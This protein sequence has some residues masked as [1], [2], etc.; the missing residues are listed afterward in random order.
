MALEFESLVPAGKWGDDCR[1]P[2]ID[3]S[4]LKRDAVMRSIPRF[5]YRYEDNTSQMLVLE[6]NYAVTEAESECDPSLASAEILDCEVLIPNQKLISIGFG[7]TPYTQFMQRFCRARDFVRF[8]TIFMGDGSIDMGQPIAG[9]FLRYVLGELSGVLMFRLR[10]IF[11]NGDSANTHEFDGVLTQLAAGPISTGGGCELYNHVALDWATLTGGSGPTSVYA[12]IDVAQDSILIHGKAYTGNAGKSLVFLLRDWMVAV[13]E[14]WLEAWNELPM[15]FD[16]WVPKGMKPVLAE[17]IACM[18]PCNGC[19]NPMEDPLIRD[20]AASFVTTGKV[21]FYPYSDWAVTIRETRYLNADS[22]IILM[23]KM[24]GNRPT[25]GWVFRDQQR[26]QDILNGLLPFYGREIGGIN[27]GPPLYDMT[28]ISPISPDMFEE[29]AFSIDVQK[30]GNC[31][32]AFINTQASVLLYAVHTWLVIDN[33]SNSALYPVEL[34]E[35]MSKLVT[36]TIAVGGQTA[37][38][39]LTVAD[40]ETLPGGISLADTVAVYF[41]DGVTQLIGTVVSY[42]AGTNILRLSFTVDPITPTDFKSA[43]A[44]FGPL[45]VTKIATN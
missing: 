29:R 43:A 23:P 22:K 8:P 17:A 6:R 3:Y 10:E 15:E 44:S 25:I 1:W 9:E 12:T 28:E 13:M 30:N 39:D 33:V 36:A 26:E 41:S 7:D 19:P 27:D 18:Q 32:S 38:L 34:Q 4:T 45:S 14:E 11:W 20:R 21:W 37:Q 2:V 42:D 24:I 40:M 5:M 35:S 16:L 31:L